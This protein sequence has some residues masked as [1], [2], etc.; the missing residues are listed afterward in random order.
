MSNELNPFPENEITPFYDSSGHAL[1]YLHSDGKYFYHYDGTPIAYLYNHQ[2]IISYLGQYLGWLHNG[3]II[4][5]K[6]GRY[7]FFTSHSSDGVSRPGRK[8]KP[9]RSS[10]QSRPA[11]SSRMSRPSRPSR[12]S[13]W[14]ENSN[15]TF[16]PNY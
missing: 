1:F 15:M 8:S 14:S 12:S 16:F 6:N 2:C 7:A 10:R 4:D 11:E 13:G 3:S 9:S 5:Y